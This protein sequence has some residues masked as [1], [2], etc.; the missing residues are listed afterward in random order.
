M[1]IEKVNVSHLHFADD[2][3][4]LMTGEQRNVL[5]LKSLIRCFESVPD[6]KKLWPKAHL[7]GISI[8]QSECLQL[9]NV[10]GCAHKG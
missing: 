3:L 1:G 8:P 9:E 7:S 5:I 10:L 2:A 6:Y 4:L